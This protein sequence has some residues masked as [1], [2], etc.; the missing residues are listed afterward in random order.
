MASVYIQNPSA[1][2]YAFRFQDWQIQSAETNVVIWAPY[3]DPLSR[4][5][6]YAPPWDNQYHEPSSGYLAIPMVK[7]CTYHFS[8]F[9]YF[10]PTI[11]LY[12]QYGFQIK[13]AYSGSS[14]VS[15]DFVAKE[16]AHHYVYVTAQYAY[17]HSN[18]DI[19]I[20]E[21]VGTAFVNSP[22]ESRFPI[23][24][25]TTT[26]NASFTYSVPVGAFIDKDAND[27]ITY[28]AKLDNGDPLPSWLTF[29]PSTRTFSGIPN[30]TDKGEVSIRVIA[31]DTSNASS[32]DTFSIKIEHPRVT[33][34]GATGID[35]FI[36]GSGDDT[37]DGRTGIDTAIYSGQF[38]EYTLTKTTSGYIVSSNTD[39]TDALTNVERLQFS[40]KKIALDFNGSA[41][42]TVKLIGAAFGQTYLTN[43]Q[44]IGIGLSLF[45][46]GMTLKEVA[47]LV[48]E[49][50]AF[51]QLSG[52]R[53]NAD[54]VACIYKNVVGV[55]PLMSELN[56]FAD[57]LT[58]GM[59][60]GD[61]LVLAANTNLNEIHINFI[62]LA[63][64]GIEFS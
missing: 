36:S 50:S 56:Y 21:D 24:D 6:Q 3:I 14:S 23:P 61:L 44:Y 55:A 33:F 30:P 37:M 9:S 1:W 64:T 34:T 8:T 39:G 7:G 20:Y 40:D 4:P 12:D 59:S 31:T 46:S 51:L 48:L 52:T 10:D 47:N 32:L 27:T 5:S 60:Q 49:S 13:E 16:T 15:F 54:V 58:N 53:S 26:I 11:H 43:K 22:P 45:D 17:A 38:I 63:Q 41:G 57:M 35:T 29:N 28:T 2:D 19:T 25:L 62:G 18:P 42:N